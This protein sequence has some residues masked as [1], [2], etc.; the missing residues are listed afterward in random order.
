[1]ICAVLAA[2]LVLYLPAGAQAWFPGDS[3]G[4]IAFEGGA[5][6]PHIFTVNPDGSGQRQLTSG[7]AQDDAPSFSPSGARI[8]YAH[9]VGT[10]SGP[11]GLAITSIYSMPAGG[12]TPTRL[13][14]GKASDNWPAWSPNGL[15]MIFVRRVADTDNVWTMRA[16]GGFATPLTALPA[17]TS[18]N[19]PIFSP[20]GTH[21]V[22]SAAMGGPAGARAFASTR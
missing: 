17:D 20:D 12:G 14:A 22:F 4:K 19:G 10:T 2:A 7:S 13:T 21:I 16:D 8:A 15:N 18:V 5:G 6:V 3:E 11:L 9:Q 1:M